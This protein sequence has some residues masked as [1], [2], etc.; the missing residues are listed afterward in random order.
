MN[1]TAAKSARPPWAIVAWV[2]DNS[3][4]TEIPCVS[5]PPLI[6]KYALTEGGLSTAL[7]FLRHFHRQHQP[8]GGDYKITLQA[9]IKT[10]KVSGTS[11][12]REKAREILKKLRIT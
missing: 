3:I 4:Y 2:D 10:P 1:A 9:N 12:E 8:K 11:A 5:G 7:N 6:Q